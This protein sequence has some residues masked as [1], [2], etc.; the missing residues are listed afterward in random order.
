[1]SKS[2]KIDSDQRL[3]RHKRL[4]AYNFVIGYIALKPEF[5]RRINADQEGV[6]HK[7]LC[8]DIL[9]HYPAQILKDA[10]IAP[11]QIHRD[12]SILIEAL[13]SLVGNGVMK[14]FMPDNYYTWNFVDTPIEYYIKKIKPRLTQDQR[15]ELEKIAK[16]V[17]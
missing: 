6:Y 5:D 7:E 17:K 12:S 15:S 11:H 9:S 2:I 8:D 10:L 16:K 4:D 1:M 13:G 14:Q 3:D